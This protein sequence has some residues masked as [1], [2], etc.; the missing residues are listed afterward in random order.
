MLAGNWK[1]SRMVAH[2]SAGVDRTAA[3]S[4]YDPKRH[5]EQAAFRGL[6]ARLMDEK[7]EPSSS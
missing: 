2:Y 5:R 1:T 3:D 4:R 6:V 7:R